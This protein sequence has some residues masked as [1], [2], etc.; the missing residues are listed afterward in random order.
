[1]DAARAGIGEID[2]GGD[3]RAHAL[4]RAVMLRDQHGHLD[5]VHADLVQ[6]AGVRRR[7]G[8]D[9]GQ[10]AQRVFP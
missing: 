4:R 3:A 1:M 6:A 10:A 5:R 9:V 2:A 7:F 8:R